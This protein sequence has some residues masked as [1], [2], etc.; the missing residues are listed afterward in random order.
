MSQKDWDDFVQYRGGKPRVIDEEEGGDEEIVGPGPGP[1]VDSDLVE[2]DPVGRLVLRRKNVVLYGPPGTGKT[3]AS[4]ALAEKWRRSFGQ[5]AVLQVTFHP[6][7]AYEDFVEGFRPNA[8]GRFERRDGI[9]IQACD[10]AH[11]DG[12]RQFLLIIDELNRGDV[13]RLFG[14]LITLIE[15]DKRHAGVSR[16]LPYSRRELWVP[17]NLHLLGTMN[18]ADRSISLLDVAIRRRF[19]FVEYR[20]DPLVINGSAAHHHEAGGIGIADLMDG[21]N[22]RLLAVGI[23]R[24]RAVGHSHF[25]VAASEVRPHDVLRDRLRHDVMPLVEE[26]CYADRSLMR[27]V[28]GSLVTDDGR[29]D[30]EVFADDAAFAAAIRSIA[31]GRDGFGG[32]GGGEDLPGGFDRPEDD[33]A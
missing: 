11:A 8:E 13:A 1:V 7:F 33:L 32:G 24:D 28:F 12:R 17:P 22:R 5:D 30:E 15:A 25:L 16:Q 27:R 20:P 18:T 14:E 29:A 3:H 6:T 2:S 9:F 4:L 31:E 19:C 26:Y 23:D 10:R 21:I